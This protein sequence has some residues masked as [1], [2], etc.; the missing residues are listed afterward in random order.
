MGIKTRKDRMLGKLFTQ[1]PD[2][3]E[4]KRVKMKLCPKKILFP[5][6]AISVLLLL[7]RGGLAEETQ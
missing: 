6:V 7:S 2:L 1:F 3:V 4:R 5:A